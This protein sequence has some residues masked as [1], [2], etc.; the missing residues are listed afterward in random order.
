MNQMIIDERPRRMT[1][2]WGRGNDMLCRAYD[3]TQIGKKYRLPVPWHY[4]ASEGQGQHFKVKYATLTCIG[5]YKHFA[6]FLTPTKLTV[7]FNWYDLARE[8]SKGAVL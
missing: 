1:R 8:Y 5:K 2:V 4:E 6:V 3:L 7:C